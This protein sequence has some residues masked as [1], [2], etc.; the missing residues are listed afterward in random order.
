[1]IASYYEDRASGITLY[2]GRCEDVLPQLALASVDCVMADPPYGETS[3]TWDRR[4]KGWPALVRP[5]LKP[6]G[7]MWVWGS[8]KAHLQTAQEF[9][10]W[11]LAQDVIWQK[12]NGS[13]FANDRFRRIHEQALQWYAGAKWGGVYK[14]PQFTPDATKR[15]TRRKGKPTHTG[16]IGGK[17]HISHDGGP[18]LMR[19]IIEAHSCH[20][21]A[22]NETQKPEAVI[23]PLIEYSCPPGGLVLSPFAGSGTDLV[24]AR[25]S[26]R[27]AIGIEMRESQCREIVERLRQ[28]VLPLTTA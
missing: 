6:S 9:T 27:H 21:Y 17:V 12:H 13:N 4:V 1:M 3:L 18:R 26:G 16:N 7:S 24:V 20:G 11:R 2:H 19:S 22:V 23:R 28:A 10:D 15:V 25:A 8:V 14:A 5:L